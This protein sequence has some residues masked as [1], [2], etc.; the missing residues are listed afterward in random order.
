MSTSNFEYP[1]E[2]GYPDGIG[3]LTQDQVTL[4]EEVN[5]DDHSPTINFFVSNNEEISTYEA[6]S[7]DTVIGG[8]TYSLTGTKRV[9]LIA[10]AVFPEYRG[11]GVAT[12]LI[13][14]VLDDIRDRG[15]TVTILC[16]IVWAFIDRNP[17]YNDLVDPTLPGLRK[18]RPES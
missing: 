2:A 7:G 17:E 3:T 11:Q 12:E 1:D 9:V 15:N 14:R 16:P 10:A 18:T 6:I 5:T 8:L 4:I 13:R